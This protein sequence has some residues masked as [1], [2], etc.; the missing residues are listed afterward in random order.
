VQHVTDLLTTEERGE[1][2]HL[3]FIYL[4]IYFVQKLTDKVGTEG[5]WFDSQQKAMTVFFTFTT[6]LQ[7]GVGTHNPIQR[8]HRS[9]L[10]NDGR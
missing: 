9:F 5:L 6:E 8:I 1:S 10:G 3:L 7:K 4:F 2:K